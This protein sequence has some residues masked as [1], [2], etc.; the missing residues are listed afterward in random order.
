[1]PEAALKLTAVRFL[2]NLLITAIVVACLLGLC[3]FVIALFSDERLLGLG[4]VMSVAMLYSTGQAVALI[5][6][7][8]TADLR[9]QKSVWRWLFN[10]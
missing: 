5:Y 2:K 6:R 8:W 10:P 7:V 3:A 1:M 9:C 4:I